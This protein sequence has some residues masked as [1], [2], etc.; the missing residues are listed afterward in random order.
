MDHGHGGIEA[1][2]DV[3][4]GEA[5]CW[6]LRVELGSLFGLRRDGEI[7][8]HET[9][10][11]KSQLAIKITTGSLNARVRS[12]SLP[13]AVRALI[14]SLGLAVG[15]AL[16]YI[17]RA[18]IRRRAAAQASAAFDFSYEVLGRRLV[19]TILC[20]LEGAPEVGAP[21]DG[22]HEGREGVRALA[23]A[24]A[25][26]A[27]A[28]VPSHAVVQDAGDDGGA[29]MRNELWI[30][31]PRKRGQGV[32]LKSAEGAMRASLREVGH[33]KWAVCKGDHGSA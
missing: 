29:G 16:L 18:L 27:D 3:P 6:H 12:S 20:D 10:T 5:P 33:G 14:F 31:L 21:G 22:I 11:L 32:L 30:A 7:V 17:R 15:A 23:G 4:V 8:G 24:R 13:G 1:N 2:G 25:R 28:R 9:T 26:A 19:L